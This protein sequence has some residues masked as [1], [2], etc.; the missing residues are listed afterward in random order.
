MESK[1]IIVLSEFEHVLIRP[2]IYIGSVEKSEEKIP[3][4][5][6]GKIISKEKTIS[7]G[8]YKLLHEILDNAFDEAKRMK[9]KMKSITIEVFT[10]TGRVIVTDTGDGFFKGYEKN[11]K[12]G[13]SNVETAMSHLRAGSNFNNEESK[14]SLIGTNGVGASIVNMFSENFEITTS[15]GKKTYRQRW[16]NFVSKLKNITDSKSKGTSVDF[17]PRR[18]IFKDCVWD[19][20]I[21]WS[22][23]IFKQYLKKID[24]II[25]NVEFIVKI[26]GEVLDL[27]KPFLEHKN[28]VSVETK[29]GKIMLWE[30]FPKSTKISFV[31]GQMCSGLHQK[32]LQDNLNTWLK[33]EREHEFYDSFISLNLEPKDVLF[34]D[35]IKSKFKISVNVS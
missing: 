3:I 14:D 8:F 10:K 24:P 5:E 12:T 1:E 29:I 7:V 32:I 26:D 9:G 15:D 27:E 19:K 31:N 28:L 4:V 16:E 21:L 23:F 33:D 34:G 18:D 20:E 22:E 35:Q 2:T 6:N 13:L 17:T 30:S 11:V 25:K